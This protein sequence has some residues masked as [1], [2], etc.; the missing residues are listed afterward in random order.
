MKVLEPIL[1]VFILLFFCQCSREN[2]EVESFRYF[3]GGE[4]VEEKIVSATDTVTTFEIVEGEKNVF[5]YSKS[6]AEDPDVIDDE[7]SLLVR[8]HLD[9]TLEEFS[10]SDEELS[11]IGAYHWEF[12]LG[13]VRHSLQHGTISGE[14]IDESTWNIT[15]DIEELQGNFD[16]IFASGHYNEIES[17]FKEEE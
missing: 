4:I 15:I 8:F 9:P 12:A 5:L 14:K 6:L 13:G 3:Q 10:Y 17:W 7:V 16:E 2:M 11:E 1:G